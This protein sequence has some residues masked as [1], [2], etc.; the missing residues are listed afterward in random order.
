MRSLLMPMVLS[1]MFISL[2]SAAFADEAV[3]S[4][5]GGQWGYWQPIVLTQWVDPQGRPDRSGGLWNVEPSAGWRK[6]RRVTSYRWY[7]ET[8]PE[9]PLGLIWGPGPENK[10]FKGRMEAVHAAPNVHS[11]FRSATPKEWERMMKRAE[12]Y[13]GP[14]F[15]WVPGQVPRC[16]PYSLDSQESGRAP[17]PNPE[18]EKGS[19]N[20]S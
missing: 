11:Q 9:W 3:F 10:F 7:G 6:V 19:G 12:F 15:D 1:V 20:S 4:P 2:C 8:K 13:C 5:Y 17:A 16:R 14:R 18:G